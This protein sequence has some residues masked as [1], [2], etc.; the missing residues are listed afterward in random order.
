MARASCLLSRVRL[1]VK[2]LNP[3]RAS[4]VNAYVTRPHYSRHER[5]GCS[6]FLLAHQP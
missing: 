6:L 3:G 5:E 2:P 4:A 1:R